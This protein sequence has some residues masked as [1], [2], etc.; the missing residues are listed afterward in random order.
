MALTDNSD[1][2]SPQNNGDTASA[3]VGPAQAAAMAMTPDQHA[4]AKSSAGNILG[5]IETAVHEAG[6]VLELFPPN[7]IAYKI[8]AF[9]DRWF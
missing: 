4:Q 5:A 3:P 8:G 2:S 7:T 9:L 1:S 6:V